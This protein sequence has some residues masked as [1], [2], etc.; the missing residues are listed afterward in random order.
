MTVAGIITRQ[1]F[2]HSIAPVLVEAG[3]AYRT[4][5]ENG[6][7][8]R[9][10]YIDPSII[11]SWLAYGHYRKAKITSGEWISRRK[12]SLADWQLAQDQAQSESA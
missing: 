6:N 10:L 5:D 2:Y 9:Y 8:S 11:P 4:T 12:W 1:Q 3:L 7:Q